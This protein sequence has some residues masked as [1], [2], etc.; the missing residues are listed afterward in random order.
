MSLDFDPDKLELT[1]D[2]QGLPSVAVCNQIDTDMFGKTTGEKR[3]P[4][5][6][7]D[8]GASPGTKI[9]GIGPP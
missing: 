3:A 5:P 7:A 4:G 8:P 1:M 6:F 2:A 9:F